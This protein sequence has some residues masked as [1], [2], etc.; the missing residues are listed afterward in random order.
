MRKPRCATLALIATWAGIVVLFVAVVWI[1]QPSAVTIGRLAS[2]DPPVGRVVI[3]NCY[4]GKQTGRHLVFT[5]PDPAHH[6][7]VLTLPNSNP[8]SV[9][10]F[11]GYCVGMVDTEVAG[12]TLPFALVIDCHPVN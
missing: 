12:V 10:V 4:N 7:V 6:T 9:T 5:C 1:P 3:R 11:T 2:K 8:V